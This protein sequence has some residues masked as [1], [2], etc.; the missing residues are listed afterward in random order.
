MSRQT[1]KR[2]RVEEHDGVR[3]YSAGAW[4]GWAEVLGLIFVFVLFGAGLTLFVFG[5]HW[6]GGIYQEVFDMFNVSWLGRVFSFVLSGLFDLTIIAVLAFVCLLIPYLLLYDLSPKRFW[7]K[8]DALYHTSY[9]LGCIPH[10]RRLRF[11]QILD[12]AAEKSTGGYTLTVR[13]ERDL[14]TWV[15]IILVF[16]NERLTQWAIRLVNGIGT[17][18]EAFALQSVLLEPMTCGQST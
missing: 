6:I 14:P 12:I 1:V 9:L 3:V 11:E 17:Q 16:W 5:V 7:I 18:E 10:T 8:G 15:F 13:Y 2:V 4:P